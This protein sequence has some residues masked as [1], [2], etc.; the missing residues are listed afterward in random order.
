MQQDH[1]QVIGIYFIISKGCLLNVYV[2]KAVH[3]W[4]PVRAWKECCCGR[5]QGWPV[6]TTAFPQPSRFHRN[7]TTRPQQPPLTA[8]TVLNLQ[9][10]LTSD[11]AHLS[12]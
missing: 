12:T 10:P 6:P 1:A 4:V 8:C 5:V 3:P 7:K 9:R 2:N 11:T